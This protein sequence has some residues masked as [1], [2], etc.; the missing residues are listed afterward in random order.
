MKKIILLIMFVS[1]ISLTAFGQTLNR[2]DYK[3]NKKDKR[4]EEEFKRLHAYEAEIILRGD[5]AALDNF[6]P[7]DHIV[8]NPFNQ[9]IDKKRFWSVCGETSSS[10][11]LT[12]RRWNIY[13]VTKTRLSLRELKRARR[14]T[15]QTD[16]MPDK[17]LSVVL[18]KL[19]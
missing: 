6:Y 18:P 12:K 2:C 16:P 8:T 14:R 13:A 5:V 15:T 10:T 1:P 17:H 7:E 4:I 3:D 9:M 11:N 19:G